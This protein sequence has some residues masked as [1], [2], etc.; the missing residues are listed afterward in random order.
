MKASKGSSSRS[1]EAD[2]VAND[3]CTW[4]EVK[5]QESFGLGSSHFTG[6]ARGLWQQAQDLMEAAAWPVNHRRGRP[7]AVVLFFPSGA[8]PEVAAQLRS[9][10]VHVLVGPDGLKDL[11][12]PPPPPTLLNL[13]TTAMCGLVSEMSHAGPTD[14]GIREWSRGSSHWTECFDAELAEP[15][16][17]SALAS[18]KEAASGHGAWK[19]VACEQAVTQF[20]KLMATHGGPKERAR[21]LVL[22]LRIQVHA[23]LPQQQSVKLQQQLQHKAQKQQAKLDKQ[24]LKRRATLQLQQQRVEAAAVQTSHLNDPDAVCDTSAPQ[25]PSHHETPTTLVTE[26]DPI[27]G[28][29]QRKQRPV[30][31]S[32]PAACTGGDLASHGPVHPPPASTNVEQTHRAGTCCLVTTTAISERVAALEHIGAHQ[33]AV[34]GLGDRLHALTVT[35]DGNAVRSA[36]KQGLAL[37]TLVHRPVWLTGR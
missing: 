5:N 25:T 37:E 8:A 33:R 16:L 17:T 36:Q 4:I 6:G 30:I 20:E 29:Q 31:Q 32:Q 28:L 26:A 9:L 18:C 34:L 22:L 23:L 7:P 12:S 10:G 13:D 2:V 27:T 3:G 35:A 19:L 1:V 15:L 21:W 11:P 24:Q 14:A